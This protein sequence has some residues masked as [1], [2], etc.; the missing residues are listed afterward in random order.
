[1]TLAPVGASLTILTLEARRRER[2]RRRANELDA[3]AERAGLWDLRLA[4]GTRLSPAEVEALVLERAAAVPEGA[5]A[6]LYLEGID[7]EAYRLLDMEAVRDAARGALL[8]KLEPQFASS[9]S[10]VE[11]PDLQALPTQWAGYVEGQDL[12]GFDRQ[13]IRRLG[14]DYLSRAVE[15]AVG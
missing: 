4:P 2:E 10:R 11:L 3:A 13:R 5:V 9:E 14:D 12:T 6:R 7:A 8:L 1:M 15:E